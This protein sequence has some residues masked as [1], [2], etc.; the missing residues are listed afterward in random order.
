MKKQFKFNYIILIPVLAMLLLFAGCRAST[1]TYSAEDVIHYDE[2]YDASDKRKIVSALVEPLV[3]DTFPLARYNQRPVLVVYGIANR[4]SEHI[5]TDGITDD[6][7]MELLR[8]GKYTF[9]NETQ[10]ANIE[11]EMSYQYGG[12]VAQET[13]LQNARQLGA[14]YMLT[15]TLRSIEK[16]EPRQVR[17]HKRTLKYYSLNIEITNI[18]TSVIEWA[19]KV[20]IVRESAK[21]FIGW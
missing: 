20:E 8:S 1:T 10:R 16:K 4:T 19:D 14:Q 18:E 13:R 21:P 3:Q 11:R 9:V 15:G 2:S 7:R 5:S 12:N 17:V 6:I